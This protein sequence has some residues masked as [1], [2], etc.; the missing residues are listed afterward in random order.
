[1]SSRARIHW[2]IALPLSPFTLFFDSIHIQVDRNVSFKVYSRYNWTRFLRTRMSTC[3]QRVSSKRTRVVGQASKINRFF[4][5]YKRA[6]T[7]ILSNYRF[8]LCLPDVF[9]YQ[10][11]QGHGNIHDG[12]SLTEYFSTLLKAMLQVAYDKSPNIQAYPDSGWI[13]KVEMQNIR[14]YTRASVEAVNHDRFW[15]LFWKL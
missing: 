11:Q 12:Y 6:K 9:T 3:R 5:K 7:V 14:V 15:R 2:S 1:M 10:L 8:F 13:V 4:W